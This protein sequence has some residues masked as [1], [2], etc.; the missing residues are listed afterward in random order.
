[1]SDFNHKHL[2]SVVEHIERVQQAT[3]KLG[4]RLIEYGEEGFGLTLIANGLMHD[5]SKLQGIEWD[6]LVRVN[7]DDD[8]KAKEHLQIA[9][10]QH[11]E[12]NPHHP[13][14]WGSINEMPRIYVAEMVCDWY[15]RQAEMGTDFRGWIKDDASKKYDFSLNGKIYKQIKFFVEMLLDPEFKPMAKPDKVEEKSDK[16]ESS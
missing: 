12:T 8:D 2:E 15:A 1:M 7:K 5:Q 13:E 16:A 9:W 4:K 6:F 10:R 11:V 3:L 14:Y